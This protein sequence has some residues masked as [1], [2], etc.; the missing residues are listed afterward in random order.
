MAEG[1]RY[2]YKM[3][4]YLVNEITLNL[5]TYFKFNHFHFLLQEILHKLKKLYS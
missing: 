1:K 3:D 2:G 5:K 4:T